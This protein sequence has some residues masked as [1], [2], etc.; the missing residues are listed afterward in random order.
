MTEP[1][2]VIIGHDGIFVTRDAGKAWTRVANLKPKEGNYVFSPNWFGCYA[3]DPLNHILY[4]S[5]MGNPVYS[6]RL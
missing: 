1:E 2:M 6:L 3:W 5:A 4:A